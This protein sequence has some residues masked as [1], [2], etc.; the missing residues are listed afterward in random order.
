M[1]KQVEI[2]ANNLIGQKPFQDFIKFQATQ[3]IK[4]T[5]GIQPWYLPKEQRQRLVSEINILQ[6]GELGEIVINGYIGNN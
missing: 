5:G 6:K 2:K 4:Y 3:V 1:N